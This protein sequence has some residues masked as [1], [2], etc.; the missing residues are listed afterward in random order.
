MTRSHKRSE[1]TQALKKSVSPEAAQPWGDVLEE[2]TLMID[3]ILVPL[4]LF[5]LTVFVEH[6]QPVCVILVNIGVLSSCLLQ[7][8][9]MV[10]RLFYPT[11]ATFPERKRKRRQCPE[12]LTT[13]GKYLFFS[14][15]PP[16]F[17]HN[18]LCMCAHKYT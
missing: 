18:S 4:E 11:P 2:I 9:S 8:Q 1:M 3:R 6:T 16:T 13:I 12:K 17:N 15:P 7:R 10:M 5:A 14:P